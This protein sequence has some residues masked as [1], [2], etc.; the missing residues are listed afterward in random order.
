MPIFQVQY[1]NTCN[2]YLMQID[3]D[4]IH[5]QRALL[6]HAFLDFTIIS[7]THGQA[8]YYNVYEPN[9]QKLRVPLYKLLKKD[10]CGIS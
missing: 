4:H 2:K 10:Q 7:R 1:K 9:M 6:K 5:P 8:S 3:V